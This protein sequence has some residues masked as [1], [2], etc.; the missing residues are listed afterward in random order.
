MVVI[1]D[2]VTL[3][4]LFPTPDCALRVRVVMVFEDEIDWEING[5]V[6]ELEFADRSKIIINRQEPL[7]QIWVATK[8]N[9]HHFEYKDGPW[10]DNREGG[11]LLSFLSAA[12][13]KQSGIK[14]N[15]TH[16]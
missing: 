11:E 13:E 4:A 2:R 16:A 14:V 9:G 12:I 10:I 1:F 15:L 7:H 3:L 8:F 5:S 6:L